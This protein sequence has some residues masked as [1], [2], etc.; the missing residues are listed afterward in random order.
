MLGLFVSYFLGNQNVED[1]AQ[2][3]AE[4][5]TLESKIDALEQSVAALRTMQ[6][7]RKAPVIVSYCRGQC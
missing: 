5:Q 1:A 3:L 2:E 4:F 7:D 6:E